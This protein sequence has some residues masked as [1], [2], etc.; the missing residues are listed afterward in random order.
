MQYLTEK[1]KEEIDTMEDI[2]FTDEE[3]EQLN[4]LEEKIKEI[5]LDTEDFDDVFEDIDL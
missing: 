5:G 4:A 1:L 3:I 2:E